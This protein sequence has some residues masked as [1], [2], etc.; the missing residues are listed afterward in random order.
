[1]KINKLTFFALIFSITLCRI[2]NEV[3]SLENLEYS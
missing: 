2:E 3:D 1:M